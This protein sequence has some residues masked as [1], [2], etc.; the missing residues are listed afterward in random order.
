MSNEHAPSRS[1]R[2]PFQ[3]L[4]LPWRM[5]GGVPLYA[6]FRRSYGDYWQFIAGGGEGT[7]T[8]MRAAVRESREEAGIP[9]TAG[10]IELQ[11]RNTV[12]VLELCG[13]LQW[14][15]DVLV[16]P[17]HT[18]GVE[19]DS[20]DLQLSAEHNEYRW[21]DYETAR[22]MLHWDSNRNALLEL[23]HRILTSG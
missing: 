21:V 10:F 3:V 5:S 17:E 15:P 13:Y 16:V 18:F 4:V 20:R 8:P 7:E 2:A 12:P 14:G 23:N 1:T 6:I 19:V 11:S 22:R 9:D